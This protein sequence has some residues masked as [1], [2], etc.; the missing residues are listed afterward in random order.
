MVQTVGL[1]LG[2]SEKFSR[3]PVSGWQEG[4]GREQP[5]GGRELFQQVLILRFRLRHRWIGLHCVLFV[6]EQLAGDVQKEGITLWKLKKYLRSMNSEIL[7]D[8]SELRP[9]RVA[10]TTVASL[11]ALDVFLCDRSVEW[12][13]LARYGRELSCLRAPFFGRYFLEVG[14]LMSLGASIRAGF[15]QGDAVARPQF[16]TFCW[17]FKMTTGAYC[18][19]HSPSGPS[20][21]EKGR[22]ADNYYSGRRILESFSDWQE[23]LG[24]SDRRLRLRPSWRLA[25]REGDVV[26]WVRLWRPNV[27]ERFVRAACPRGDL[28]AIVDLLD[29]IPDESAGEKTLRTDFHLMLINDLSAVYKMLH[30]AEAWILAVSARKAGWGGARKGSGRRPTLKQPLEQPVTSP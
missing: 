24:R 10:S 16:C 9:G 21:H 17:R 14:R 25:V 22:A 29:L 7:K 18:S 23:R 27:Y 28:A 2:L 11:K 5:L 6:L 26:E 19:I 15:G 8:V 20:L 4:L 1:G 3:A 30:R 13:S 12:D